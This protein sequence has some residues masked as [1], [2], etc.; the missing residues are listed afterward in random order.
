MHEN[1]FVKSG[2][3]IFGREL[4]KAGRIVLKGRPPWKSFLG[5]RKQVFQESLGEEALNP[6]LKRFLK[7][8]T[9]LG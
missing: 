8:S 4:P 9:Q 6:R 1:P 3:R 7:R 5:K 2:P